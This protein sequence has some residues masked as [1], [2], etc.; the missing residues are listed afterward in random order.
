MI[1]RNADPTNASLETIPNIT[2]MRIH[3]QLMLI[4]VTLA[5]MALPASALTL[6]TGQSAD[7]SG[8]NQTSYLNFSTGLS[9]DKDTLNEWAV[10]DSITLSFDFSFTSVLTTSSIARNT[11]FGLI[12]SGSTDSVVYAQ[13]DPYTDATTDTD[14]S[15]FSYRDGS[16]FMA[17][18]GADVGNAYS[19]SFLWDNAPPNGG[20]TSYSISFS[21]TKATAST[22]QLIMSIG[23]QNFVD[24]V[25]LPSSV[26]DSVIDQ[27]GFRDAGTMFNGHLASN[28]TATFSTVT[29]PEP[30]A[31]SVIAAVPAIAM[32]SGLRRRHRSANVTKS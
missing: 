15:S 13:L 2:T 10:G 28:I 30:S 8:T 12:S 1:E 16:I 6:L 20:T 25:T 9:S 4:G 18:G 14:T 19:T 21:I 32:A 22:Y 17:N 26:T 5:A 27:I 31:S 11:S 24:I 23:G 7:F 3:T 29:I